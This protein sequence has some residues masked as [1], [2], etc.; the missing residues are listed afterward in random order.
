MNKVD[1]NIFDLVTDE[2]DRQV[3]KWGVQ[4]HPSVDRI[5]STRNPYPKDRICEE[6]EIPTEERAK[7]LCDTHAERG[8]LTWAHIIVE[9]LSEV[10]S[11]PNEEL[12]KEELIQLIAVAT[13]W[14]KS[15]DRKN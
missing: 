12:R 4:N 7:Q 2:M 13:S 5:L 6:Y 14:I 10:V 15:I 1:T 8:D 9:E 11:A 3:K